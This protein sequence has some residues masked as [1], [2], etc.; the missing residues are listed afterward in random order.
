[1]V[2][3][4]SWFA[5]LI[6]TSLTSDVT[7]SL[8]CPT[9][10]GEW[11]RASLAL[12]C[13]L[14]NSYHCLKDEKNVI[15]EQCLAKVWIEGEMCPV[16]SSRMSKIDVIE[17]STPSCPQ[18]TYWSN[19][20]FLYP[21]C[22][23][24]NH[25]TPKATHRSTSNEQSTLTTY[26]MTPLNY[27]PREKTQEIEDTKLMRGRGEDED[28]SNTTIYMVVGI[29]VAVA[30]IMVILLT[31]LL[32]RKKKG[33][34][35]SDHN[36]EDGDNL[37]NERLLGIKFVDEK[38]IP[39]L[40]KNQDKK[41]LNALTE[42]SSLP[43]RSI[44]EES[45]KSTKESCQVYIASGPNL[46]E[47]PEPKLSPQIL[48]LVSNDLV[49]IGQINKEV[50][51]TFG[52]KYVHSRAISYYKTHETEQPASVLLKEFD[53]KNASVGEILQKLQEVVSRVETRVTFVVTVPLM[54][55]S[56]N[57][58]NLVRIAEGNDK[59]VCVIKFV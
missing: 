4:N 53:F 34:K 54:T 5:L 35:S 57:R 26:N 50:Q 1:M 11:E 10:A 13:K 33:C 47:Q 45:A 52:R 22:F 43:N 29:C 27:D 16:Y 12:Q 6:V 58:D 41:S 20:V 49:E 24:T 23:E 7:V 32:G 59:L 28:R 9:S 31:V 46:K 51:E 44:P 2:R 55:W 18:S 19:S 40:E 3:I 8:Q 17:C 15:T 56:S 37:N 36:E 39:T 38:Q 48:V 14:P 21:V 25:E 30:V 42:K